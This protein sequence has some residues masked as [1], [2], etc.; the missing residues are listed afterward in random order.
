MAKKE[1][2]KKRQKS[3]VAKFLKKHRKMVKE[4][5]VAVAALF[6]VGAMAL[7]ARQYSI[8]KKNNN[9][10]SQ[11]I[12][13]NLESFKTKA[14]EEEEAL[15]SPAVDTENWQAYSNQ[16]YGFKLKY[17]SDWKKPIAQAPSRGAKWQ[18]RYLFRKNETE[19]EEE[20]P[21]LGFD[22]VVYEAEK[23]KGTENTTE[24]LELKKEESETDSS[25]PSFENYLFENQNFL[26]KEVYIPPKDDCYETGFFYTLT[27]DEYIYNLVP[28]RKKDAEKP[29]NSKA[30]VIKKFP[31]FFGAADSLDFLEIA[32]PVSQ[33][34]LSSQKS[35]KS[36]G[37]ACVRIPASILANLKNPPVPPDGKMKDGKLICH[38]LA[39]GHKDNPHKSQRNPKGQWGG[40]CYDP[41]EVPNPRCCYPV[42]SVYEKYLYRY[43]A[44]PFPLRK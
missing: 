43:F 1:E 4:I 38:V 14:A 9:N 8:L 21:Y 32:K 19:T 25:C 40:C 17:P 12:E 2:R 30:E 24:F 42:G 7:A 26:A 29:S 36:S 13:P 6:A 18:V 22:V 28:V 33:K 31:E 15:D 39:D 11:V 27:R 3:L 16:Y 23:T 41:D 34:D 5:L 35:T 44:N 10:I 20:N 37:I